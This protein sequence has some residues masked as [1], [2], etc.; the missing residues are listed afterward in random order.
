MNLVKLFEMK[1]RTPNSRSK[2]K[3][4]LL[5]CATCGA[6]RIGFAPTK[7]TTK[8]TKCVGDNNATHR[9]S[10]TRLYLAHASMKKRC[11]NESDNAFSQYG[12]RGI[13]VCREWREYSNF[14]EWA[15]NNGYNDT[16]TL[17]RID[18]DKGYSPENCRWVSASVQSANRRMPKNNTSG[19]IGVSRKDGS[20]TASVCYKGV[21]IFF[22]GFETAEEAAKVRDRYIIENKLPHTLNF[23]NEVA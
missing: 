23:K 16:M 9:E 1:H 3:Y 10:R 20:Y 13:K 21:R 6:Q 11:S 8:C 12:A 7:R 19:Y 4:G 22:N 2:S 15:K 17:D 14:A 18:N 5:E